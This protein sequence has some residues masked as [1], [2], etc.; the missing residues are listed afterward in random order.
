MN[1]QY[2]HFL[3]LYII[4]NYGRIAQTR[5]MTELGS[6]PE[7]NSAIRAAGRSNVS[8]FPRG[9]ELFIDLLRFVFSALSI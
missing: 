3:A 7:L 9:T 1:L 4:R 8:N 6:Q 5:E 2:A